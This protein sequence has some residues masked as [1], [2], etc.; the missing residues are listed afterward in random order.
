MLSFVISLQPSNK[1]TCESVNKDVAHRMI[2]H[3]LGKGASPKTSKKSAGM[4]AN[5]Q[6][7]TAEQRHS[8]NELSSPLP[9]EKR[10]GV[11]HG[12]QEVQQHSS[13]PMSTVQKPTTLR[14]YQRGSDGAVKKLYMD[15][16]GEE[17]LRLVY[18][19]E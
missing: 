12:G 2:V 14:T 13:T 3:A 16:E 15:M 4:V 11:Q 8:D 18:F 17:D 7:P 1:P 19:I 10:T 5:K 9:T 6:T